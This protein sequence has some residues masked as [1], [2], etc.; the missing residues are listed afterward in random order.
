MDSKIGFT[1]SH[2]DWNDDYHHQY[3]YIWKAK[4][5]RFRVCYMHWHCHW[6][7]FGEKMCSNIE[8][9]KGSLQDSTKNEAHKYW[10]PEHY[11]NCEKTPDDILCPNFQEICI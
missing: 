4:D 3:Y 1:C 11:E 9:M 2:E 5:V 10:C 8:C 6:M 7:N